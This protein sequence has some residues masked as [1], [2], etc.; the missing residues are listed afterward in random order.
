MNVMCVNPGPPRSN[1]H[2][3]ERQADDAAAQEQGQPG[4]EDRLVRTRI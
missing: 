3:F 2:G 1:E 4:R